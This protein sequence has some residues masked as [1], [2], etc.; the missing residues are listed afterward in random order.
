MATVALI[1]SVL[2]IIL[3]AGAVF[4]GGVMQLL[5]GWIGRVLRYIFSY[6]VVKD[7]YIKIKPNYAPTR[8]RRINFDDIVDVTP[9]RGHRGIWIEAL[10]LDKK[11]GKSSVYITGN[12]RNA[13]KFCNYF[14]EVFGKTPPVEESE[15]EE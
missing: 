7:G 12:A 13:E 9:F 1:A 4:Y 8:K 2:M 3:G 11:T 5:F 10:P 6:A 14:W 15:A